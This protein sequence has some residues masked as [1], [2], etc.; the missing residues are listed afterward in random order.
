MKIKDIFY[1][2]FKM[3]IR[4]KGLWI[5]YTL[6]FLFYGLI[7][8]NGSR[9]VENAGMSTSE[10]W[11]MNGLTAFMFNLIPPV[12]AGIAAADRL[13]RDRQLKVDE[14]Q[15]S[16]TVRPAE[17]L[18]GKYLGAVAAVA[19][20]VLAWIFLYRVWFIARGAPI[21]TLWM[22]LV[23]F[24]VINLPAYLFVAAFS[25]VC[26]LVIP[27]RVYQVLFT[28]YWFWGNYIYPDLF[29]SLSGT[30]F[31]AS[32][33]IPANLLFGTVVDMGTTRQVFNWTDMALYSGFI[34]FGICLI[35][36]AGN[37]Y[38]RGKRNSA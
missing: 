10:L 26:P 31:N 33:R 23:T 28:G 17:Y 11:N 18:L 30:P 2:E 3:G 29:P 6:I 32:G 27:T 35:L 37:E 4:R 5:A 34:V 16:T 21:L 25:L 36:L 19:L 14:L 15:Q 1:Y 13:V 12:V 38:L 8:F 24:A 7:L 20:P 9:F 22:T